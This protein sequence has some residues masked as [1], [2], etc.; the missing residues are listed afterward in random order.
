MLG[1][2]V[3]QNTINGKAG[4]AVITLRQ[5]FDQVEN[6]AKFL[7]MHPKVNNVDPLMTE[8]GYTADEAYALRVFF[9]TMYQLQQSNIATFDIGRKLSGLE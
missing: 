8:F 4:Q 5:A 1:Y 3:D 6:L 7:A 9:E 2:Y